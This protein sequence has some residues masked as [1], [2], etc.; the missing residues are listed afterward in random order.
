MPICC[1][2]TSDNFCLCTNASAC[3]SSVIFAT[4]ISVRKCICQFVS[5]LFLVYQ[6]TLKVM[7]LQML[8]GNIASIGASIYVMVQFK[9]HCQVS[10]I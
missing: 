2:F 1:E 5:N 9:D 10:Q 4:Y 6:S 7:K 3:E 8:Q